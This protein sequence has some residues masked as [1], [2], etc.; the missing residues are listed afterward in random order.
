MKPKKEHQLK[1]H[2]EVI[3]LIACE[4]DVSKLTD[5]QFRVNGRIDLYPMNLRFHNLATDERGFYPNDGM[6]LARFLGKKM[7]I[8]ESDIDFTMFEKAKSA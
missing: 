5:F 1:Q 4:F 8:A 2:M 6:G 7:R 3:D